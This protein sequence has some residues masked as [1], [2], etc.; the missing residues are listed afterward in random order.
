[1]L[2]ISIEGIVLNICIPSSYQRGGGGLPIGYCWRSPGGGCRIIIWPP[3]AGIV[4]RAVRICAYEPKT[5]REKHAGITLKIGG[6][7][8]EIIGKILDASLPISLA[9]TIPQ[10]IRSSFFLRSQ[11]MKRLTLG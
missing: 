2:E 7:A 8:H 4:K 9:K 1:M 6:I 10:L 3:I 5:F 11:L